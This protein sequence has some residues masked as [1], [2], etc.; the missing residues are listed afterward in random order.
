MS[1]RG[2]ARLWLAQRVTAAVLA[3]CVAVH[4]ATIVYA[5]RGGLSAADVLSRTRGNIAWM[6]FYGLFVTAAATHGSIGIRTVAMEW[7]GWRKAPADVL[8]CVIALGL[9]ALGMQAVYAVVRA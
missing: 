3:L 7:L 5:V 6:V 4:L 8:M 2:E 9:A 1:A